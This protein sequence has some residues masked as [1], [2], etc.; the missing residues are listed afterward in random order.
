MKIIYV[1]F[2]ITLSSLFIANPSNAQQWVEMMKNPNANFYE[3]QAA[4][5]AYWAGKT[6]QKGK[7]YKAFKRWEN[8]MA[9]R[10]YPTGNITLPS[11]SYKNYKQ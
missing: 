8:Y 5:E 3:T 9:P 11:Q 1:V 2:W 6:I 10:V 7:G 4:F